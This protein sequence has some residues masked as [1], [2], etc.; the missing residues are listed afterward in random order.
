MTE[1]KIARFEIPSLDFEPMRLA[2]LYPDMVFIKFALSREG[3]SEIWVFEK[4]FIVCL[5][6]IVK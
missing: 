4:C 2:D 1:L 3:S 5:T 6:K